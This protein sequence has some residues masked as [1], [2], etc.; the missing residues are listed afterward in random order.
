[1]YGQKEPDKTET[2]DCISAESKTPPEY[3]IE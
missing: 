1:M 3:D 2:T